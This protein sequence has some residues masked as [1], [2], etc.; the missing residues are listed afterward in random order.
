[1][2]GMRG[3]RS[4][5]GQ[6]ERCV[7]CA[8]RHCTERTWTISCV[9]QGLSKVPPKIPPTPPWRFNPALC[10]NEG[11]ALHAWHRTHK[12][13]SRSQ[14][15]S[16]SSLA[17]PSKSSRLTRATRATAPSTST[18]KGLQGPELL[19]VVVA[20]VLATSLQQATRPNLACP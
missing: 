7:L 3:L 11:C 9:N 19:Q 18:G 15:S 5:V 20:E 12:A 16:T 1:M 10:C 17:N 6:P 2:V 13:S 8:W 4:G 14:S